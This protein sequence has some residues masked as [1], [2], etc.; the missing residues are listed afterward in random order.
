MAIDIY[1]GQ[2]KRL[3]IPEPVFVLLEAAQAELAKKT[4]REIDAYGTTTLEPAHAGHWL[5]GLR[6]VLPTLRQ[7]ALAE[8]ACKDL[9]ALLADVIEKEQTII[10]EGE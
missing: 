8:R 2:T 5:S 3:S 9:I 7:N 1:Q 4:G 6:R 10:V